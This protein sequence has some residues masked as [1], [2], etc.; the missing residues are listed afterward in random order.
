MRHA[1]LGLG[2]HRHRRPAV[3]IDEYIGVRSL[4]RS[5]RERFGV[6]TCVV[7]RLHNRMVEES[8]RF[9]FPKLV[10]HAVLFLEIQN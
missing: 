2:Q 3:Y 9:C 8:D 4:Y 10:G 6:W 1:A 5:D 7:G